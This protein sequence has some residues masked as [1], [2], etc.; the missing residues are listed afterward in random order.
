MTTGTGAIAGRWSGRPEWRLT[1]HF[2]RALFD[3]GILSSA[4]ADSFRH[5]LLGGAGGIASLGLLI[6]YLYAGKYAMLRGASPE[7]FRRAVLGDDLMLVGLPMLFVAFV[8][9]LVSHSLFPDER[10]LRVLGPL[11]VDKPVVFGTKLAALLLFTGLFAAVAHAALVPLV[12]LTSLNPFGESAVLARLGT[13]A[14]TGAAASL[15]AVLA[16]TA[17]V[18]VF[19]L[20]C[21]TSRFQALAAIIRSVLLGA[22]VVCVPLVLR[23]SNSGGAMAA[24]SPWLAL[25]PP[26][27]FV[28]AQHVLRGSADAWHFR[29]AVIAMAALGA[30]AAIV[31]AA[32][33]VLFRHFERLMLR[34]ASSAAQR[35]GGLRITAFAGPSAACRA[36]HSFTLLTLR[37]SHLHQGVLV[38]LIACG[39]GVAVN[40]LVEATMIESTGATGPSSTALLDVMLWT[41]FGLMCVCGLALRATAVLP[42][43]H[44]ANWI[45]RFTED[46]ATRAEQFRA[47]DRIATAC[48]IGVPTV[49][50]V[51]LTWMLPGPA[52]AAAPAIVALIGLV[53]VDVVLHNW[54]RLPFTASYLPGKR[55]L[56]HSFLLACF[57]Y[58]MFTFAGDGL[59]G[60]RR[61]A[62]RG[63]LARPCCCWRRR[64]CSSAVAS[65]AGGARRSCSK[66]RVR[67]S[68]F[69]WNCGGNVSPVEVLRRLLVLAADELDQLFVGDQALA[70]LH[71]GPRARIGLEVF[72]R[73][74]DF[75]RP[76][77]DAPKPLGQLCRIGQRRAVDVEPAAILEA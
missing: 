53:V 36:V 34:P 15:W 58:A 9:L 11:P 57:G 76:V 74:V 71:R 43:E 18:G 33:G 63:R 29:L 48:L 61:S 54:R 6:T 62:W 31:A 25:V 50:A 5:M 12:L 68:R 37:R 30:A 14:V 21:S 65:P 28:G 32:Y 17:I 52:A 77:V 4:G 49:T 41:P 24:G 42:I 2:F 69:S 56:A 75:E 45:F 27:W 59:C 19:M 13:W 3:F 16:V 47:V 55:F 46:E 67:I 35:G 70:D 73:H 39:M 51:P 1:V 64:H 10:D 20:W 44:R 72:D 26:A 7:I 23:L 22:L 8:T 66:I 60:R 38:G 40:R